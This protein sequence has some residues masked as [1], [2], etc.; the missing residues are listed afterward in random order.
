M[1]HL[2]VKTHGK[3]ILISFHYLLVSH[4]ILVYSSLTQLILPPLSNDAGLLVLSLGICTREGGGGDCTWEYSTL[5]AAQ[6]SE[7]KLEKWNVLPTNKIMIGSSKNK[8][9]SSFNGRYV[10]WLEDIKLEYFKRQN[11]Q[12]LRQVK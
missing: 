6:S 11:M 2:Y 10:M 8:Q 9:Q 5:C 3:A 12:E 4:L 1:W 7:Q